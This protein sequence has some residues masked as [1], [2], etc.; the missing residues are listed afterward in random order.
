MISG[1]IFQCATER[2][3]ML[4]WFFSLFLLHV[5]LTSS[6]PWFDT[7]LKIQVFWEGHKNPKL[8]MLLTIFSF[9]RQFDEFFSLIQYIF[10]NS[11]YLTNE[12]R[13]IDAFLKFGSSEKATKFEKNLRCT[14]D[15]SVVFFA[16]NSVLVKILTKTIQNK[17]SKVVLYKL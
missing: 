15:K 7:Y 17:R 2:S 1:K 12:L 14:F 11:A 4:S 16:Q 8:L 9:T 3:K 13:T 5:K 6:F 10:E